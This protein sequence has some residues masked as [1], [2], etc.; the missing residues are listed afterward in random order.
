V[1][2][3]GARPVFP[4]DSGW[5][6]RDRAAGDLPIHRAPVAAQRPLQ[7]VCSRS[8]PMPPGR[9]RGSPRRRSRHL[10]RGRRR[11]PRALL[12]RLGRRLLPARLCL[13]SEP[14][15]DDEHERDE[16][17]TPQRSRS[18]HGCSPVVG[19]GGGD[20]SVAGGAKRIFSAPF[21]GR[22]AKRA[23]DTSGAKLRSERLAQNSGW[24]GASRYAITM[25]RIRSRSPRSTQSWTSTDG[26]LS[27]R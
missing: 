23:S 2:G 20:D 3:P 21:G 16:G 10:P 4:G 15:G 1:P 9:E 11:H 24:P 12:L 19:F 27:D 26:F 25:H 14:T 17:K 22:N 13:G 8:S 18:H 7:R 5:P 6:D